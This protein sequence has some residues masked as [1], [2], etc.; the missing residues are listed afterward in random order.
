[1]RA[2]SS[3]CAVL[4]VSF[5]SEELGAQFVEREQTFGLLVLVGVSLAIRL[6]EL[7]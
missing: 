1:M 5:Q 6:G 7:L 3:L 4:R 2:S